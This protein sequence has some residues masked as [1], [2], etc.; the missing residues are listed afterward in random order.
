[1]PSSPLSRRDYVQRPR[2]TGALFRRE[3]HEPAGPQTKPFDTMRR[4]AGGVQ[5]DTSD[6]PDGE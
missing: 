2:P 5:S 4:P 6:F 3:T 1:M